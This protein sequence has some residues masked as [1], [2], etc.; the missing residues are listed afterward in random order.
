MPDK[1][2]LDVPMHSIPPLHLWA[3]VN[4]C[5]IPVCT[6]GT[7]FNRVYTNGY[8]VCVCH[9]WLLGNGDVSQCYTVSPHKRFYF[10][11]CFFFNECLAQIEWFLYYRFTAYLLHFY[12]FQ[13]YTKISLCV[14]LFKNVLWFKNRPIPSAWLYTKIYWFYLFVKHTRLDLNNKK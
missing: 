13:F 8:S 3:N 14:H 5:S 1:Q 6:L 2:R 7:S 11:A 12:L 9:L 4:T 10:Q